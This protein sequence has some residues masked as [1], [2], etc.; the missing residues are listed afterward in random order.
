MRS[1]T[2]FSPAVFAAVVILTALSAAGPVGAVIVDHTSCDSVDGIPKST[3]DDIRTTFD[4]FYGHTSHGSQ[5]VSGMQILDRQDDTRYRIPA[6]YE[7]SDDLGHNG[8]TSWMA[9]TRTYLDAHPECNFVMWSWCGGCSDNT[10]EGIA[11]YLAAMETLEAEYPG[12]IFIYMTGHLDGTGVDGNLYRSNNQIRDY[13]VAHDKHLFD[14]AD[15]ES[16]DPAGTYYPDETD[17]CTWCSDWCGENECL[18]CYSCAHSHCFNCFR[19]G[20]AFWVMLAEIANLPLAATGDIP[21]NPTI[22]LVNYPN[23]FNPQTEVRLNLAAAGTGRMT[24]HSLSGH[25]IATL[26]EGLFAAGEQSFLWNGRDDQGRHQG[27]GIYLCRVEV[28]DQRQE[29]KMTLL[30]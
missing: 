29:I 26:H 11:T 22:Q 6:L 15:I 30:K 14:F 13:C 17:A 24:I 18:S 19:K 9:P 8:D 7:I 3:L 25:H 5:I 21:T 10:E 1:T 4:I 16:W 12:K 27:S 28:G 2:T 23:P 20:Q